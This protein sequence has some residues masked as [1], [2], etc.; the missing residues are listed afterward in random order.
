MHELMLGWFL[1]CAL[2]LCVCAVWALQDR[3]RHKEA[4]AAEAERAAKT[5]VA[6]AER[7]A[8]AEAAEA[9]RA[10]KAEAAEAERAFKRSTTACIKCGERLPKWFVS[11]FKELGGNICLRCETGGFEPYPESDQTEDDYVTK[12][13]GRHAVLPPG[14]PPKK[15]DEP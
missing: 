12:R 7:A 4:L 11:R 15:E 1:V 5:E 6:E 9:E 10:A 13:K 14:A 3:R 8:K 2:V